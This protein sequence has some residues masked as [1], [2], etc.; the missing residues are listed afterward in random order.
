[1]AN[2]RF[3][4]DPYRPA[5]SDPAMTDTE[6][7]RA[8]QTDSQ[9]Q[10]DPELSEGRTSGGKIAAY[11]LGIAILLG[12]V[13]Y[14]LS[15][16]SNHDQASNPPPT[17]SAATQPAPNSPAPNTAPGVTTGA[18]SNR[19][20]QPTPSQQQ[21]GSDVDQSAPQPTGQNNNTH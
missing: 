15:N 9:M 18:A 6:Y 11:A 19:P 12:A 13:F 2:E 7:N 3:P 16:S 1:M 14:G 10:P 21:G 20:A 17:K 4:N 5:M 8:A